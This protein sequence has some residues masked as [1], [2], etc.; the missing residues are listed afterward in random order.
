MH[1]AEADEGREGEKKR[2]GVKPTATD[3]EGGGGYILGASS[4]S[5]STVEKWKGGDNHLTKV[6]E[7]RGGRGVKKLSTNIWP[8]RCRR[9]SR[10]HP[11]SPSPPS[12][13]LSPLSS[14]TLTSP[15]HS[16][17]PAISPQS[18]KPMLNGQTSL[19]PFRPNFPFFHVISGP[20]S[21]ERENKFCRAE[22]SRHRKGL[23]LCETLN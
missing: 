23:E 8:R 10:R 2:K 5:S 7:R 17:S 14:I 19:F 11:F 22:Q 13:L 4:S 1:V 6:G 9:R 16:P 20:F 3:C 18:A 15:R 12:W 21:M